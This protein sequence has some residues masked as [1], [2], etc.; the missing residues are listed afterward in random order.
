MHLQSG[1]NVATMAHLSPP[2]VFDR[3]FDEECD[4][5]SYDIEQTSIKDVIRFHEQKSVTDQ[6]YLNTMC[7][8]E[9]V[10]EVSVDSI[11]NSDCNQVLLVGK[12]DEIDNTNYT[13]GSIEKEHGADRELTIYRHFEG[14]VN[15]ENRVDTVHEEQPHTSSASTSNVNESDTS[16]EVEATNILIEEE[17]LIA[18]NEQDSESQTTNDTTAIQQ[19]KGKKRT[20]N[21]DTWKRNVAK[22]K[23]LKGVEYE[24]ASHNCK[25]VI[26]DRSIKPQCSETCRMK[27]SLKLNEQQRQKLNTSFWS[28][29][30][31]WGQR[32][33]YLSTCIMVRPVA[34]ERCRSEG[35]KKSR[36]TSRSFYFH[37]EGE[38]IQVCQRMFLNTL[39][40]TEKYVSTVLKKTADA[41]VV[42]RDERGK[43]T[44]A[45][46]SADV[47]IEGIR[48]HIDKYPAYES[49]YSREKSKRKYLGP[50]LNL[51]LMYKMYFDEGKK[52]NT[53]EKSVGSEWLY[54]KIFNEEFNISF[55]PPTNDTCDTCDTFKVSIHDERNSTAKDTLQQQHQD[56]LKEANVRYTLKSADKERARSAT[57]EHVVMF[58]M[59]KCLP[60]PSLKNT[61]AFYLRKLWVLNETIYDSTTETAHC[62]MWDE[63]VGARGGN[64]VASCIVKWAQNSLPS[65][66]KKIT[67]WS[68]NCTGQNR[69]IMIVFCYLWLIS[70][71]DGLEVI[72]HKFM[73]KG[74]TH[75]EVDAVHSV[76]EKKKKQLKDFEI[77]VPRDWEQ[78]IKTVKMKK[79]HCNVQH[80]SLDD[81]LDFNSLGAGNTSPFVSRRTDTNGDPFLI[82]KVVWLRVS[83]DHPGKVLYKTSFSDDFKTLDLRRNQRKTLS[84]PNSLKRV[85]A[86]PRPVNTAKYKDLITLTQWIP[87][88]CRDFYKNLP[89]TTSA[90]DFP[91]ADT[92][93]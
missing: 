1:E 91:E 66:V 72:D 41:G 67:F 16:N 27:C 45:N 75:L 46:K 31:S 80:L 70:K 14:T 68:D 19:R 92:T 59:E 7:S 82:S 8:D 48:S 78:F 64:E 53:H 38:R 60:T 2:G 83:K 34:R 51:S 6:N 79:K 29:F 26:K 87:T 37:N 86:S 50:E 54:R 12:Q 65:E 84:L 77:C 58:D 40:I 24:S 47:I 73:L 42:L 25:S 30:S 4:N 93:E 9:R 23:R 44:P 63:S 20:R 55:H 15:V 61:Q 62:M 36:M 28:N 85:R 57:G 88:H 74:H 17:T 56:H 10:T 71:I 32:N 11:A 13:V 5:I 39:S 49:H 33:Q 22:Q 69:N 3:I 35:R 43:H 18:E 21:P 52:N 81:F 89:H 76:I 90:T